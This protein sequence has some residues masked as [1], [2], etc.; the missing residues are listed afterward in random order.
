MT[1]DQ[2][3]EIMKEADAEFTEL[4]GHRMELGRQKYGEGKFLTVDTL[5]EALFEI[6]DLANY[7]RFTFIRIRALQV[8][9]E[10]ED[11]RATSEDFTKDLD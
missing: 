3:L 10:E 8:K 9:L 7:A 5:N 1:K 4:C 11:V 2:L 6:A